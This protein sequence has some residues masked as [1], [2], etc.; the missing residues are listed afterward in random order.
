MND[1]QHHSPSPLQQADFSR[2]GEDQPVEKSAFTLDD[3]DDEE[4]QPLHSMPSTTGSSQEETKSVVK[5]RTLSD[6][7]DER[8]SKQAPAEDNEE[9][10]PEEAQKRTDELIQK[11]LQED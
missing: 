5:K 3:E 11:M 2:E 10:S 9:L 4:T 1:S 8:H 6:A 7:M